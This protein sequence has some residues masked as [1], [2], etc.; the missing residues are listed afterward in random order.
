V[1]FDL[2]ECSQHTRKVNAV[3]GTQLG[4]ARLNDISNVY[5]TAHPGSVLSSPRK[6][7]PLYKS[8]NRVINFRV[9]D[10]ELAKLQWASRAQ[11]ARCLSEFARTVM[12]ATAPGADV[13]TASD[14]GM[15]PTLQSLDGRLAAVE[16]GLARVI[17][18]LLP[19]D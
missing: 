15:E 13:V 10:E 1:L 6:A 12:L 9:T 7:Q 17:D 8:R 18:K 4:E 5:A 19:T 16:S 14:A 3:R 2:L 11:G